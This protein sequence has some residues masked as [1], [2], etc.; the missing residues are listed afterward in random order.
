MGEDATRE[1]LKN[2]TSRYGP[3]M[4]D[5]LTTDKDHEKAREFIKSAM[6]MKKE[7][8]EQFWK[9]IKLA[10]EAYGKYK[11]DTAAE[12]ADMLQEQSSMHMPK[13][14]A[15]VEDM[16]TVKAE[17]EEFMGLR[18]K[19]PD[20]F[21]KLV[22]RAQED[23]ETYM[24]ASPELV[25]IT[26]PSEEEAMLE[27]LKP[28]SGDLTDEEKK[29]IKKAFDDLPDEEKKKIK[30][31]L[32]GKGKAKKVKKEALL[33]ILKPT[34]LTD[35]EKK[36]IKEAFDGLPEETKKKIWKI[37]E[38]KG[39]KVEK[40]ALLEILQPTDEEKK[41][42]KKDGSEEE[43]K[44]KKVKKEALLEILQPTD[45][46]K[47]KIKKDGPEEEGKGKKVKKEALLEI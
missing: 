41:K 15:D 43:G 27:I 10:M 21:W 29:K 46:E 20:E 13:A 23:Y 33:E 32:E 11:E 8:P 14:D 12:S 22:A 35:E 47:K 28:T 42:I 1:A 31:I 26:N 34:A 19:N 40:E 6:K 2:A 39:K 45:E 25:E 24:M 17:F 36:K 4:N 38:E 5:T 9:M 44:G 3:G 30:K 37:L 18:E 16:E 7:N